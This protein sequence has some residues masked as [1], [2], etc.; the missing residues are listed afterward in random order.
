MRGRLYRHGTRLWVGFHS[1]E[2]ELKG[3]TDFV[4]MIK[5]AETDD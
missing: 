5:Q 2:E 1:L 3:R 4:K